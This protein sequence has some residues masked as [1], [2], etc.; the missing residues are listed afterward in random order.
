MGATT[1]DMELDDE[2]RRV[3]RVLATGR[4]NP[5]LIREETGLGKGTVNTRLNQ[6][7]RNG[8]VEQVTTGLYELTEKGRAEVSGDA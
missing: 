8:H 2:H 4:A 6:L 1:A 7:G 3:L 5:Y